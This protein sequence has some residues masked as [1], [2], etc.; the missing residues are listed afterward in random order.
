MPVAEP[1]PIQ[2]REMHAWP[3]IGAVA[4]SLDRSVK[5][6]RQLIEDGDLKPYDFQGQ[7][8]FDPRDVEKLASDLSFIPL[9]DEEPS[10]QS[11]FKGGKNESVALHYMLEENRSLR[12]QLGQQH[13]AYLELQREIR[14][15]FRASSES[16]DQTITFLSAR[17]NTLEGTQLA[18]I[19]ARE[20]LLDAR[21]E[22]E[23]TRDRA[24]A[25]NKITQDIWETT[26][27]NFGELI[28][29]A[30]QRFAIDP[31]SVQKMNAAAE[32][33]QSLASTPER[34]EAM[35]QTGLIT[36]EE[37]QLLRVVLGEAMPTVETTATAADTADTTT[38]EQSSES[39]NSTEQAAPVADP[40]PA[41][42][43]T[44]ATTAEQAQPNGE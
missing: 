37:A 33:L 25:R 4:K 20:A 35:I 19:E 10:A 36:P 42:E 9:D 31:Q 34:V 26:K 30:M 41:Q 32:L 16:K 11:T 22:R 2:K 40:E 14:Q 28:K 15:Q 44:E 39:T 1:T 24:K 5:A 29:M 18:A 7:R 12:T 27:S 8:R 13:A 21:E 3:G 23:I 6:I 17:C 38:A 43:A